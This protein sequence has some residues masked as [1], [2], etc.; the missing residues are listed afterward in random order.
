MKHDVLV[1]GAGVSGMTA[2][3]LLAQRGL[4]V[5]L[6]EAS[7]NVGP[8]IRGFYRAG[9][10]FDTGFHYTGLLEKNELLGSLLHQLG[11]WEKLTCVPLSNTQGDYIACA[12]PAFS[13]QL[14]QHFDANEALLQEQFPA[15][16]Q[17]IAAYFREVR[18]LWETVPYAM[19]RMG[20]DQLSIADKLESQDVLS[21]FRERISD[22]LLIAL[23]CA[24][25]MLYGMPPEKTSVFYHAMVAGSYYG[26]SYQ[27][28][29]GGRALADAFKETMLQ[30]GVHICTGLRVTAISLS[31]SG[32]FQGVV[33][34]KEDEPIMAKSC[35]FSGDPRLL[36]ELLPEKAMRPIYRKRLRDLQDT[37]SAFVLFGVLPESNGG[38]SGNIVLVQDTTPGIGALDGP[39]ETRP[40]F[41]AK[42]CGPQ[43]RSGICV[44]C[45]MLGASN[46]IPREGT[47][48]A[49][50]EWKHHTAETIRSLLE[51]RN[52]ELFSDFKVLDAATPL[53]FRRYCNSLSG[54]IY[55]VQHR[56]GNVP[57]LPR[58]RVRGLLL[59]GQGTLSVGILGA[60]MSG[61]ISV[62]ALQE[63]LR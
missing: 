34:D 45:P 3:L 12:N 25:G 7:D 24:H 18:A 17:A 10:Y 40:I 52:P 22:P 27:I 55:G 43:G 6:V 16:R 4:S 26:Q 63:Q 41:A 5:G 13:L 21:Y 8:T 57:I 60:V 28:Q 39:L 56:A 38:L 20:A 44:I 49:Y 61:F 2:A 59:T 58:T 35:V 32:D 42:S 36:L 37:M 50:R 62:N 47:N 46:E 9:H 30:A 23:L 53:T 33:T 31:E 11:V 1:I 15:E 48:G 54:A 14:T 51:S 19:L 29:G